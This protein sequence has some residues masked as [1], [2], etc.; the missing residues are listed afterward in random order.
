M[1]LQGEAHHGRGVLVARQECPLP[2]LGVFVTVVPQATGPVVLLQP[3]IREELP[4]PGDPGEL[5]V[6]T[7]NE[8]FID[9]FEM[10]QRGPA[11]AIA[12]HHDRGWG[13]PHGHG[14]DGGVAYFVHGTAGFRVDHAALFQQTVENVQKNLSGFVPLIN[15]AQNAFEVLKT[16]R[17]EIRA[18]SVPVFNL[19]QRKNLFPVHN[20]Y[21]LN[22]IS[23]NPFFPSPLIPTVQTGPEASVV[24]A[25]F[26]RDTFRPRGPA[27][28]I[29]GL[30][31]TM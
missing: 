15:G 22:L 2:R 10:F 6:V 7:I 20:S 12:V 21:P 30:S 1:P 11:Q 18:K 4:I 17:K 5:H 9:V 13:V 23:S 31:P 3:A 26:R 19:Y 28:Y 16:A 29:V 27:T 8:D 25:K 24:L 14:A